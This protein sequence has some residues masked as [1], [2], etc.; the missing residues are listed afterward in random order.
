MF[1]TQKHEIFFGENDI[2]GNVLA[3][4]MISGRLSVAVAE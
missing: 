1:W 3:D 2:Q 4:C